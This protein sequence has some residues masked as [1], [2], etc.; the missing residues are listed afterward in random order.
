MDTVCR[1]AVPLPGFEDLECSNVYVIGT[2]PV[3]LV[4]TA[5]KFPGSLDVL[6]RQLFDAG[7]SWSDVEKIIITHGHIDHFGLVGA[8]RARAPSPVPCYVH[9]DD[10]WRLSGDF[11]ESGMWG[12]ELERFYASAGVPAGI[13]ERI[14]RRFVFF[15]NLCD[16]VSDAIPMRD[17]QVFPGKGF[18]LRVIHTPGH[19]PGCCCLYEQGSKILFTGDHVLRNIT[20]NPFHEANRSRLKDASYKSLKA[21]TASLGRIEPLDVHVALPGH[22]QCI[23]DLGA[24]ISSYRAHHASRIRAVE[25]AMERPGRSIYDIALSI[26][27]PLDVSHVSLAVSEVY[28]HMEMLMES[29]GAVIVDV[30]PP[31]LYGRP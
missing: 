2:G 26:F 21:Y 29:G 8:I 16:P 20:P 10:L 30:G 12:S 15:R 14:R 17:G 19:S 23:E 27:G 28:V 9:E 25:E 24:L 31:V 1:L 3:T 7:F 4:D 6:E 22:G 5:P 13:V 18:E 11:L